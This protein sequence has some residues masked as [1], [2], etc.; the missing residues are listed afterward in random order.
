LKSP[1][2]RIRITRVGWLFI[3]FCLGIGVAGLNTG[4]N[5]L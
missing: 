2:F 5:L 1:R 4:N 3:S